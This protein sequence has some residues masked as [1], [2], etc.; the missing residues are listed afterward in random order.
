MTMKLK[1][2]LSALLATVMAA[3][4]LAL[5]SANVTA[6][7]ELPFKDVGKKKWFYDEVKYVYDNGL[8]NGTSKTLFEPETSLTRAMFVTILGR[9][10]KAEENDNYK[11]FTD[12]KK[13]S[14]YT[15][16]VGWAVEQGIVDGYPDGTF[17]PDKAL[18]REEMA[19]CISRYIDAMELNSP[20]RARHPSCSRTARR[21]RSGR[22]ITWKHC[23]ARASRTATRRK[24]ITRRQASRAPR[25]RR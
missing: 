22:V 21:S 7:D 5:A 18:T 23:A 20:A 10:A 14:W 19:A 17:L 8:M 6:A 25:W 2:T 12:I 11:K 15:G 9:L 13:A 3:S 1:R 24:S 16:Y 4:G